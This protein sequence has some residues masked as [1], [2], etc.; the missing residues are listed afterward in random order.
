M[1]LWNACALAQRRNG[2]PPN[3]LTQHI[4]FN[5]ILKISGLDHKFPGD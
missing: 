5:L 1:I 2:V 3:Y 4:F